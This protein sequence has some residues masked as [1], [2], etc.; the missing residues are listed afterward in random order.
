MTLLGKAWRYYREYGCKE[1]LRRVQRRR[2]FVVFVKEVDA[3]TARGALDADVSF[4]VARHD[5]AALLAEANV[6]EEAV[7]DKARPADRIASD[8]VAILG[9]SPDGTGKLLYVSWISRHDRLFRLLLDGPASANDACSRRIWTPE[10]VRRRG[11]ARR[12]LRYAEKV[13]HDAGV[14]R[15]WAFV[16]AGNRASLALHRKLG[17]EQAGV[18][19]VGRHLG[20]RIAD[21]RPTGQRRWQPLPLPDPAT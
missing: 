3:G 13:A 14:P 9:V 12:G 17:Y 5:D 6:P 2:R 10:P 21:Y 11:L 20:R 16:L 1:F 19:R 7:F 15:L 4:R 18:L 8:D